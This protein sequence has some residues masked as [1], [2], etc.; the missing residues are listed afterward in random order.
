MV[1]ALIRQESF[2]TADPDVARAFIEQVYHQAPHL[3]LVGPSAVGPIVS[4]E[5][6]AAGQLM[7]ARI[8]LT[9]ELSVQVDPAA[10]MTIEVFTEGAVENYAGDST[11]RY[12]AGDVA[13]VT[14]PGLAYRCVSENVHGH[15]L[16]LPATV[17]AQA[18]GLPPGQTPK[19][20]TILRPTPVDHAAADLWRSVSSYVA[21]VLET[22]QAAASS[23][24]V[25]N[26]TR[27]LAHTALAVFATSLTADATPVLLDGADATPQTVRRA[28]AFIESN[29]DQDIALADI[30]AAAGVTPRAVQYAFRRHLDTSPLAHLRR[31]RL[32]GAHRDLLAADPAA[33]TVTAIATR[34]GFAHPGHFASHY[35][36]AYGTSPSSTLHDRV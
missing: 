22:P 6:I 36:A 2:E 1:T 28:V 18:A 14:G 30:A 8:T 4:M 20:W 3:H 5:Q 10:A 29:A 32:D 31:V 11:T 9:P 7:S 27:L 13:V 26:A 34:W 17:I 24:L 21:S 35:R 12:T 23:L 19:S 25:A 33:S 16:S 15:T